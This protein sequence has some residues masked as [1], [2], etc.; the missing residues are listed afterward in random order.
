MIVGHVEREIEQ[1]AGH[2]L[3]ANAHVLFRKVPAARAH[4]QRGG[5]F[6][7][8]IYTAIVGI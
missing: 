8:T 2:F 5:P 4:D 1:R 3:A 7:Q 6:G